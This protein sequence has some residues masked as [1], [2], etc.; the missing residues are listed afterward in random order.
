M[1]HVAVALYLLER[2]DVNAAVFAD[3]AEVVA[4]EVDEHH[5][6]GELLRIG[7]QLGFEPRILRGI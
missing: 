1:H 4:T 5:V 6:L 3:A 2:L 7:E